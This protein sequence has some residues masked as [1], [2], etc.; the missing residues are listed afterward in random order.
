LPGDAFTGCFDVLPKNKIGE[1]IQ[2]FEDYVSNE[3]K[4]HLSNEEKPGYL[5]YIEDYTT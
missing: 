2:L 1:M 5:G 4:P 3:L